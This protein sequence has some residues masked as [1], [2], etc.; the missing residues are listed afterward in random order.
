MRG[1]GVRRWKFMT[2]FIPILN[3]DW[4]L[5]VYSL[6]AQKS[7]PGTAA[8]PRQTTRE[9]CFLEF[10][11]VTC[12]GWEWAVKCAGLKAP[13]ARSSPLSTFVN[14]N[15]HALKKL[16][17]HN[18]CCNESETNQR[19]GKIGGVLGCSCQN[20][21]LEED[22]RAQANLN[23]WIVNSSFLHVY[24][25]WISLDNEWILRAA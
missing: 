11:H 3:L 17:F 14:Y 9:G 18:Q 7:S 12:V 15:N 5:F 2:A 16:P 25:S 4:V 23:V 24:Q 1:A 20:K 21:E 22:H 13:R 19:A 10:T 8:V 6:V